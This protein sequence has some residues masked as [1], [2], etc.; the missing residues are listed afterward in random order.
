MLITIPLFQNFKIL[1]MI[2]CFMIVDL[3]F[4]IL[5]N[6]IMHKTSIDKG[7]EKVMQAGKYIAMMI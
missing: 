4:I 6:H 7:A 2:T 3:L 5:A 1:V